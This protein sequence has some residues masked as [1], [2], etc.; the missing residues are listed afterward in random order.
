MELEEM[1]AL[2][3]EGL[4][5]LPMKVVAAALFGSWARGEKTRDSDVDVLVV[6]DALCDRWHR[7]GKDIARIKEEL[8]TDF[9]LDILLLTRDECVANFRNHNPLFLDIATEGIVLYDT[10]GFLARLIEETREYIAKRGIQ[11]L[12][13]GW[14]FPTRGREPTFL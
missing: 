7:R 1:V 6:A 2:L 4:K 3:R 10:D 9:P 12:P 11:K 8:L 5:K 13:G 14:R